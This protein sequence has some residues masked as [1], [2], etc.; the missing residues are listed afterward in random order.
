M[1]FL[2]SKS[3]AALGVLTLLS[4]VFALRVTL[5]QS[6]ESSRI[7]ISTIT[8][9]HI[10]SVV[11]QNKDVTDLLSALA[12]GDS[13]TVT[14]SAG[15]DGGAPNGILHNHDV[16][17]TKENLQELES[18]GSLTVDSE[19]NLNHIHAFKF[20]AEQEVRLRLPL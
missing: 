12:D 17:L 13:I 16:V 6:P 8:N 7:A 9:E 4:A 3:K 1:R 20:F 11:L 5:A 18:S 14:G 10:H 2:K 19:V 15:F